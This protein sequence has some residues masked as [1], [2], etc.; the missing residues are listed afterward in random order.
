MF[1]YERTQ[2]HTQLHGAR[3]NSTFV[4]SVRWPRG[5]PSR[6]KSPPCTTN[7]LKSERTALLSQEIQ[8]HH[9]VLQGPQQCRP[10]LTS[11]ASPEQHTSQVYPTSRLS[12]KDSPSLLS[13]EQAW[14]HPL[15]LCS[16]GHPLGGLPQPIPGSLA[17]M[18]SETTL[19][20]SLKCPSPTIRIQ[21]PQGE[22]PHLFF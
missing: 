18:Q 5:E 16:N 19:L 17:P 6:I 3:S 11:V 12:R 1:V 21:V 10:C 15:G 13:L 7:H 20:I 4:L 8:G 2:T 9:P 22:G 14:S